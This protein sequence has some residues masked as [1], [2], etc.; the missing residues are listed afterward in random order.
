M[1]NLAAPLSLHMANACH[2]PPPWTALVDVKNLTSIKK[3]ALLITIASACLAC[4]PT[5][6]TFE[7]TDSAPLT[8]TPAAAQAKRLTLL[9]VDY[10]QS[11]QEIRDQLLQTTFDV[12]T[13]FRTDRDAFQAFRFGHRIEEFYTQLPE[14]DDSFAIMLAD[15]VR[16]SDP[17]GGTDYPAM[18]ERL[19]NAAQAS[20]ANEVRIIIVG[21]GQNDAAGLSG[22]MNRYRQAAKQLASNPRVVFVRWWGVDTG[23][24]EEIRDVCAPLGPKLQIQSL[25]QNPL[26]R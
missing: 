20:Q 17:V 10:S 5:E 13:N 15:N 24:R 4:G 23:T 3:L 8:H 21:D 6:G 18:L 12:A 14:D 25:D 19:A 26:A 16:E 11:T 22:H 7:S 9:A 2:I 1:G